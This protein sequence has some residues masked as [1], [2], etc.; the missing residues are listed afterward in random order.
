M[1][2]VS[3]NTFTIAQQAELARGLTLSDMDAPLGANLRLVGLAEE[4]GGSSFP[5]IV[6]TGKIL[7][8]SEY[9]VAA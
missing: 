6:R 9:A 1:P 3:Q 2:E 7:P 5:A 8:P 4:L